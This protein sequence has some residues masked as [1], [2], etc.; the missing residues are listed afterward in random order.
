MIII[1]I[2]I[3]RCQRCTA[4]PQYIISRCTN[5]LRWESM[6]YGETDV[7]AKR[8]R[9]V[10]EISIQIQ[11]MPKLSLPNMETRGTSI[12]FDRKLVSPPSPPGPT[13]TRHH[14]GRIGEQS[15]TS[16]SR[17]LSVFLV[18]PEWETFWWSDRFHASI[19]VQKTYFWPK[20]K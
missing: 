6:R 7:N 4:E 5:Y 3:C 11:I 15:V 9:N 13:T 10:L 8:V 19:F 16:R 20:N 2:H 12:W 1:A 18:V 17:D 14:F